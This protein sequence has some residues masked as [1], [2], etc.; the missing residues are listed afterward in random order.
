MSALFPRWSNSFSRTTL[1]VAVSVP[2][3]AIGALL[4]F[5]RSPFVTQQNVQ[6][7]QPIQFDH[8]HHVGDEGID[9]RY[10]HNSVEKAS[11]AGIPPT[12]ICMNC[13]AQVWNK[14]PLLDQV[15]AHYFSD[16]PIAWNRVHNLPDYVY[17]NHSIHVNKGVGCETCHGRMDQM[18]IAEKASPMTMSWCLDCHRNPVPN[19][20]PREAITSMGWEPLT[21]HP[22]GQVTTASTP[23]EHAAATAGAGPDHA[24][25][26]SA[27]DRKR[28]QEALAQDYNVAARVNC[29]TCHR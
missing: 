25:A 10:C 5:A 6:L 15:R 22:A 21:G 24:A 19:L 28:Y 12:Q 7:E 9:C 23:T 4:A 14:S 17:F 2:A 26:D 27:G 11:S 20:R 3:V 29:T 18:P 13:H 1:L 8:R 16:T